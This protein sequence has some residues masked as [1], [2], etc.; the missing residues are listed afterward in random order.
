MME[1][2][3]FYFYKPALERVRSRLV[4]IGVGIENYFRVKVEERYGEI[5]LKKP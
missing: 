5:I 2:N 1:K 3:I 4:C